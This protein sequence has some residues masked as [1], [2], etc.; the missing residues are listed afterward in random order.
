MSESVQKYATSRIYVVD[1]V[2]WDGTLQT[3]KTLQ[4]WMGEDYKLTL[5]DNT[6]LYYEDLLT[7]K[8]ITCDYGNYVVKVDEGRF[9]ALTAYKM[10][11]L[12]KAI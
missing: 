12:Y 4:E 8:R 5:G 2:K 11:H 9:V 6:E 10:E 7:M 3:H 1:A